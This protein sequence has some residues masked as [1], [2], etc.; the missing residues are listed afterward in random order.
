LS[1]FISK[2]AT[3]LRC[4]NIELRNWVAKILAQDPVSQQRHL[5]Q[6]FIY[7]VKA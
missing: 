1:F 3:K 7:E 4:I 2:D 5:A 6:S